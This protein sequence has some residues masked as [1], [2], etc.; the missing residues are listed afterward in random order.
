MDE[1]TEKN[2][3]MRSSDG[4]CIRDYV[5]IRFKEAQRAIDKA[6]K[7]MNNRLEGMNE[8]REQLNQQA[9]T[10]VPRGEMTIINDKLMEDIR[11]LQSKVDR[12]E[13]KA[14]ANAVFLTALIAGASLILGI[15][16]FLK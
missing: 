8:F 5:D 9:T 7:M 4:I 6:E 1:K 3:V 15:L 12:A 10:F 2:P 16:N 14:S 11:I 13:G